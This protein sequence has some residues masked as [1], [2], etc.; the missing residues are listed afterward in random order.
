[1][2]VQHPLILTGQVVRL[3]PL[4]EKHLA[5]LMKLALANLEAFQYTSTPARFDQ[6][7][8]Y[9]GKAFRDRDAGTAYPFAMFE[10]T[11]GRLIG[12]TRFTE[13]SWANR[14]AE[15]GYTW[16]EPELFGSAV[17]VDSKYLLLSYLFD[18]LE[19]LRVQINT[20]TRNLHSQ[21]AIK[22][23]GA[24]LEGVL[25]HHKFAKDG[26]LRD[27]MIFSIIRPEWPEV[28]EILLTRLQRKLA[29]T[30]QC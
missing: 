20:D 29:V 7:T 17:N 19:F 1:M 23:L 2:K 30:K 13:V 10:K 22:A 11:S 9:F 27:T 6:A 3:E 8:A 4:E 24:K 16:F 28:K 21:A 12:T 5:E 18:E 14:H 26:Y 15:L 25:R